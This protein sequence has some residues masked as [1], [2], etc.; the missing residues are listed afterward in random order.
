M[1]DPGLGARHPSSQQISTLVNAGV[2]ERTL[3]KLNNWPRVTDLLSG[4][5]KMKM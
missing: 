2:K 4:R 3:K 1:Q 5:I